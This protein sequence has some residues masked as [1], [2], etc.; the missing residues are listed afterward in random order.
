VKIDSSVIGNNDV[1]VGVVDT[2]RALLIK[3]KN[4]AELA[5]SQG[6]VA[7]FVQTLAPS[8]IEAK[9]YE[10]MREKLSAALKAENVDAEVTIV[11]PK[12]FK[13]A[14]VSHVARD[15]GLVV[16]GVGGLALMWHFFKR[17]K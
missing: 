2:N 8:T 12:A 7:A 9:I 16:A 14:G 4:P 15:V 13:A 11:E 1:T 10:A 3:I 5:R 17:K 6:A